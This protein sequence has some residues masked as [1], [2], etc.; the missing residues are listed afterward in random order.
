MAHKPLVYR[1][2]QTPALML[3]M[4]ISVQHLCIEYFQTPWTPD[5]ST[6][7]IEFS[8]DE[9]RKQGVALFIRLSRTR[10]Q[11]YLW[12]A[13][14]IRWRPA[15]LLM[16]RVW[17]PCNGA[18]WACLGNAGGRQRPQPFRK[19][20]PKP[21]NLAD[22]IQEFWRAAIA[23]ACIRHVRLWMRGRAATWLI[24][25]MKDLAQAVPDSPDSDAVAALTKLW[26]PAVGRVR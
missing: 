8:G 15:A 19:I 9:L 13:L 3:A 23:M 18:R 11:T 7:L 4:Q 12:C 25:D 21:P 10:K 5:A 1:N 16:R 17:H 20:S 6:Q 24:L 26:R 22:Y 14:A 2:R